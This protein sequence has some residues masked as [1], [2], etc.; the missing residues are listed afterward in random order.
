MD[1]EYQSVYLKKV[2]IINILVLTTTFP[3]WKGDS[4]PSFVYELSKMLQKNRLNIL[5]VAPHQEGTKLFEI[6]DGIKVSRFPYFYPKKIQ[7]IAYNGGILYNLKKSNL[8]KIQVPFFCLSE[9]YFAI[10]IL[11][12]EDVDLI[13]SHWL[14][15][16][17]FI[18]AVC[19]KLFGIPHV[20]SIHGSD[21][22]TVKNSEK[23]RSICSFVLQNSDVIATNSTYTKGIIESMY[24]QVINK[25]NVVPMGVDID[26]FKREN[27]PVKDEN[28]KSDFR[29]ITV[30]RLIDWKG[31]KYLI[32]AMK[33][34]VNSI[35]N[36]KLFVIGDG[37]EKEN[38]TKL[39]NSLH[40]QNNVVFTGYV[41][42]TD[43]TAYYCSA[44][45]FVLPSI[46]LNGH[47]EAL[48]VVILE[49]MA[50]GV[51]VI[52]TSVGGV[53]DI[54][55]NGYN[56]FLVPEKSPE[57][58]SNKIIELL[59]NKQIRYKFIENGVNT[60]RST[61][62]WTGISKNVINLYSSVIK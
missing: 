55:K 15:P 8:A 3:R 2:I 38:L 25:I 32:L 46:N 20:V 11:R 58:L 10:K 21:I 1:D 37:P 59:L 7:T 12:Q 61:F 34:V 42:D 40:I 29:I 43:L 24:P 52:G 13:H 36:A 27:Y 49:A 30:G 31:I 50:S 5:V 19:K 14:I 35:P 17:G 57:N 45:V 48:G 51:P 4:T 33:K 56:G 41:K 9:L 23:L 18:G 28:P 39:V 47:T 16:S 54:I 26:R 53:P 62:S 6:M 22:N 60:V 44:D